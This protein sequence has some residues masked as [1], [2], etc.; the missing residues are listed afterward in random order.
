MAGA[1]WETPTTTTTRATQMSRSLS[2]SSLFRRC[3]RRRR[4]RRCRIQWRRRSRLLCRLLSSFEEMMGRQPIVIFTA[5][6]TTTAAIGTMLFSIKEKSLCFFWCGISIRERTDEKKLS[7]VFPPPSP[8]PACFNPIIGGWNGGTT[9]LLYCRL[10]SY[11][12][13]SES[14]KIHTYMTSV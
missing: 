4:R 5:T 1:I 10:K 12:R 11:S 9:V 14:K 7:S 3:R 2:L 13:K 6:T 8:P